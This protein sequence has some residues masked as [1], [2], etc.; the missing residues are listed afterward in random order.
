MNISGSLSII[1]SFFH[2]IRIVTAFKST[3][4]NAFSVFFPFFQSYPAA[5]ETLYHARPFTC[6]TTGEVFDA[7]PPPD[8]VILDVRT[9]YSPSYCQDIGL[10]L[11]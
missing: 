10:F 9:P 3:N 2:A 11:S 6:A 7:L 8:A 4:D 5:Y 1:N